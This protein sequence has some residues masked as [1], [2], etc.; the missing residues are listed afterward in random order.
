M[1]SDLNLQAAIQRS[2]Q[3][4]CE[5]KDPHAVWRMLLKRLVENKV[6]WKL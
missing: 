5:I 2:L 3:E 4:G 1:R 6:E